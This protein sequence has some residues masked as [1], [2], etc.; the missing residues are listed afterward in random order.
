MEVAGGSTEAPRLVGDAVP[1]RLIAAMTRVSAAHGYAGASVARV[2]AAAGVSRSAF[3]TYFRDREE[4][5]RAAYRVAVARAEDLLGLREGG[6]GTSCGV[7]RAAMEACTAE[8]GAARLLLFDAFAGPD[9]VRIE[10]EHLARRV[11]QSL[12]LGLAG[13]D[14]RPPVRLP[15]GAAVG[16]LWAPV[17][18]RML[19]DEAASVPDLHQPLSAWLGAYRC[20]P[21]RQWPPP[22]WRLH[23]ERCRAWAPLRASAPLLPRGR[24]A[25]P[26]VDVADARRRRILDATAQ[27]ATRGY[28][29]F[30]VSDVVSLARVPRS[31]FYAHFKDRLDACCA[32][33]TRA[34]QEAIAA[35]AA[36]FS[37]PGPWPERVWRGMRAF[38]DYTVRHPDA[39]YLDLIEAQALGSESY[40][41]RYENHMAFSIFLEEGHWQAPPARRLPPPAAEAIIG[42]VVGLMRRQIVLRRT[43]S[44]LA[45][46]P[47]AS[48]L[49]LAPALGPD[50]ALEFIDARLEEELPAP[51]RAP[52]SAPALPAPG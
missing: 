21:G 12:Q 48:Y 15:V 20:D 32:V 46:L 8:P 17:S 35:V 2:I 19:R 1:D 16:G 27:L 29:S 11:E 14:G 51:R 47:A 40:L 31:A 33:Q 34:L 28:A 43:R 10:H 41:R 3:Y 13:G 18:I 6:R 52:A 42:A 38:L 5:F 39:A 25:L 7:Q 4:C 50:A 24:A 36:H 37:L 9:S 26:S 49:V 22:S 23:A 30:S 44:M 45:I